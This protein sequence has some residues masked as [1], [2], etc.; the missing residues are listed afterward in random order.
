MVVRSAPVDLDLRARR[1]VYI[2]CND[3]V[4]DWLLAFL[5]SFRK[6][7]PNVPVVAV[8][9]DDA[10]HKTKG[11]LER[12]HV[13]LW[14][15]ESTLNVFDDIGRSIHPDNPVASH[16]FRK[17]AVF[18]GP[19]ETFL[20]LDVDIIVG[21]DISS[22]LAA[23]DRVES[24]QICFSDHEPQD[25]IIPRDS[26]WFGCDN[27]PFFNAGIFG[28]RHGVFDIRT[29]CTFFRELRVPPKSSWMTE[30]SFLNLLALTA[31]VRVAQF[32]TLLPG[33]PTRTIASRIPPDSITAH[34]GW[35]LVH[36]AGEQHGR[37]MTHW[38]LFRS[39]RCSAA[40][41][42]DA[43]IYLAW[44]SGLRPIL[45]PYLRTA[46]TFLDRGVGPSGAHR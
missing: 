21:V 25:V 40:R 5:R 37:A 11:I 9:F 44:T 3:L 23:I 12:F 43:I 45:R 29:M 2:F 27:G 8:P 41:P 26:P 28:S 16:M 39:A 10:M 34:K 30:Q 33:F 14:Q 24:A 19:L 31:G 20:Y 6:H 18:Q 38:T 7:N 42:L 22:L 17:L 15:E 46:R 32:A 13:A 36:W 4:T 1:G 35:P